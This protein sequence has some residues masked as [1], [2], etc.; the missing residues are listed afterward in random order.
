MNQALIEAAVNVVDM[1]D[2]ANTN[3]KVEKLGSRGEILKEAVERLRGIVNKDAQRTILSRDQFGSG[4]G[5][6]NRDEWLLRGN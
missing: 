4:D 5:R 6:H 1:F 3:Q 2:Q